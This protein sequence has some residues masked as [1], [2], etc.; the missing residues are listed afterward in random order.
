MLGEEHSLIHDFPE[1]EDTIVRLI[2]SDKKFTEDNKSY[3]VLD[4][5]I[6]ELELN[7]A[8]IQD[9]AMHKLKHERSILK[10]SLYK[11]LVNEKNK[12]V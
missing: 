11:Y 9:D 2:G 12:N 1:L 6:R 8:P 4:K 10:D 3:N 5:E 7:D